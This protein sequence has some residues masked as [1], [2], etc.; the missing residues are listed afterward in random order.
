MRS[1]Q[2]VEPRDINDTAVLYELTADGLIA[3]FER[4]PPRVTALT[5][6]GA[7]RILRRGH[8]FDPFVANCSEA[9][10]TTDVVS[11]ANV[12]S[13][14]AEIGSETLELDPIFDRVAAS[15][16]KL[17][18]FDSMAVVRIV[19]GEHAVLHAHTDTTAKPASESRQ[20]PITAW[21]PRLRPQRVGFRIDE[22]A[23]EL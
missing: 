5:L 13:E 7:P 10:S 15:V 19:D 14:I 11:I 21:S 4:N 9:T 17:I 16:R 8:E 2:G 3:M 20:A 6:S 18:P 1:L 12:L 22:A 23:D